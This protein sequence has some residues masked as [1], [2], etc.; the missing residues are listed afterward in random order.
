MNCNQ[1]LRKRTHFSEL[2]PV[3]ITMV[4]VESVLSMTMIHFLRASCSL[5]TLSPRLLDGF[6]TCHSNAVS[7]IE[8]VFILTGFLV[9]LEVELRNATNELRCYVLF[10]LNPCLSD[11]S[12]CSYFLENTPERPEHP[13]RSPCRRVAPQTISR[14]NL[15]SSIRLL[16]G[17]L[18]PRT[19]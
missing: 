7:V 19:S 18:V 5:I 17:E 16:S 15:S 11:E 6:S 12:L 9:S 10:I 8:R 4:I 3:P 1:Q 2:F 13:E 14:T